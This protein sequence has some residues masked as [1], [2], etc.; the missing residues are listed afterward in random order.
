MARRHHPAEF[1][2][3]LL[4]ALASLNEEAKGKQIGERLEEITQREVNIAA[5][6]ITLSRMESKDWVQIRTSAPEPGVGGKPRKLFTLTA[7]GAKALEA[8][9]EERARLWDAARVHHL[10]RG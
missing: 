5:I 3:A 8:G 4:L 10:L 2:E 1:E 7:N 9:R 6:H